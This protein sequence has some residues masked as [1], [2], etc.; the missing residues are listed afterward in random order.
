M[1]GAEAAEPVDRGEL[2]HAMS[3]PTA[4]FAALSGKMDQLGARFEGEMRALSQKVEELAAQLA[5]LQQESKDGLEAQRLW[6]QWTG[7][8]VLFNKTAAIDES[9]Q[10]SWEQIHTLSVFAAEIQE[11]GIGG[12]LASM[13]PKEGA[14]TPEA[15]TEGGR[16]G[17]EDP[18]QG[19]GTEQEPPNLPLRAPGADA[20][21]AAG[22]GSQGQ[23]SQFTSC[24]TVELMEHI[25]CGHLAP[26]WLSQ[27][28]LRARDLSKIERDAKGPED[29][30]TTLEGPVGF[31]G[32]MHTEA[33]KEGRCYAGS[34]AG[35]RGQG[36]PRR[37]CST[38]LR[39][40]CSVDSWI[41]SRHA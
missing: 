34:R 16:F 23:A 30:L 8:G 28:G 13:A 14:S 33:P 17:P 32:A 20:D 31:G 10:A 38:G 12:D 2:V 22:D 6:Q 3:G 27:Y 7:E 4:G 11:W 18:V 19:G 9:T 36:H 39:S 41:R 40:H 26:V 37:T 15:R 24:S 1:D 29:L 25:P 21:S 5:S 35:W